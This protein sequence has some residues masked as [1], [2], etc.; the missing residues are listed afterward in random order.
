MYLKCA[1]ILALLC[2][3]LLRLTSQEAVTEVSGFPALK[4]RDGLLALHRSLIETPSVTGDELAVGKFLES[5][6]SSLGLKVELQAVQ[7][8]EY[9]KPRYNVFAYPPSHRQTRVL[10]TSHIDTVPPFIDYGLTKAAT[11]EPEIRGRGS[12]DVKSG[13]AAQVFALTEL[14]ADGAIGPDDAA[15]LFVVGEEVNGGGMK[16]A[17]G[18]GLAWEAVV[19]GEPTEMK[20]VSGHKGLVIFDVRAR[21]VAAHSGYPWKGRSAV[22]AL[23]P[24]LVAIERMQIPGSDKLGD[25]TIN[26]G[27]V[28][29]GNAYNIVPENATC[30]VAVRLGGATTEQ[31]KK[32]I[33]D[34]VRGV[35]KELEV[36]FLTNGYSPVDCDVLPGFETMT[37]NY[38]TDVPN[39]QGTHKRYLYGPGSITTAHSVNEHVLVDDL[40]TSVGAYKRIVLEALKEGKKGREKGKDE[41]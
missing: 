14:L 31:A 27:M 10:L 5:H 11:G 33:V 7:D 34:T 28:R 2:A 15:L 24:A 41:L 18:L 21:G 36:T 23:I 40:V 39:L 35:D 12:N 38:G 19:F 1:P 29:G 20:L 32:I 37:V 4:D 26:I 13:V 30:G 16:A 3:F 25:T 9:P 8:R 22:S 6:L 17:N